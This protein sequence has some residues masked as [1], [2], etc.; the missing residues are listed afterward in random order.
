MTTTIHPLSRRSPS[1]TSTT[2]TQPWVLQAACRDDPEPWTD[3]TDP[4]LKAWAKSEC[5]TRCPVIDQCREAGHNEVTG[6]WA[7]VEKHAK[8]STK[9]KSRAKENT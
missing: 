1:G 6:I 2:T 3:S 8:K 9:R 7:G 5:R 4:D